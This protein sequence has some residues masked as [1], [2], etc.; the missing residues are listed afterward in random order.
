[1]RMVRID[2]RG[3]GVYIVYAPTESAVQGERFNRDSQKF[4]HGQCNSRGVKFARLLHH[5]PMAALAT[6]QVQVRTKLP[7]G[8]TTRDQRP[9]PLAMGV[10]GE[11]DRWL[12]A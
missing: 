10:G 2:G 4:P 5:V 11:T 1:M 3:V 8:V 12:R 9:Q 7:D 6:R